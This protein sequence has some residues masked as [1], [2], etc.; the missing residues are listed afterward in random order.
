MSAAGE[1]E[2]GE[3]GSQGGGE[4]QEGQLSLRSTGWRGT[5]TT[6]SPETFPALPK[7]VFKKT[8]IFIMLTRY[9]GDATKKETLISMTNL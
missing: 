6:P 2:E 4:A 1:L 5:S 9:I 3:A 7:S 8:F